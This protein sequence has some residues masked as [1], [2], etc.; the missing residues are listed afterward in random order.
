MP[1]LQIIMP[2]LPT[3]MPTLPNAFY[4]HIV[5]LLLLLNKERNSFGIGDL[6]SIFLPVN[7]WLRVN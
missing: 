3:I 4:K 1:T 5:Y 2:T 7:G 6:K